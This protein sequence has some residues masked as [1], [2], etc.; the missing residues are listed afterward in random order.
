[1][2]VGPATVPLD[3]LLIAAAV[4]GIASVQWLMGIGYEVNNVLQC[5][6]AIAV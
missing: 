3:L 6:E 2:E 1:M 5:L 4:I